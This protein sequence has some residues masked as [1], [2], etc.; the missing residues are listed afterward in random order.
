LQRAQAQVGLATIAGVAGDGPVTVAY[1]TAAGHQPVQRAGHT[2]HVALEAA[3]KVGN[4]R[5]VVI[6]HGSGGS[7]WGL[8]DLAEALV[9]A[10]YVVAFPEHAGD[11]A[12]DSGRVGP[13]SW[14]RRPAEVSRAIDAVGADARF[15]TLLKL[16]M[17]GMYGMS[18]GGHTAL[19]LAGGSWS[20]AGLLRHCEQHIRSDFTA[21]AGPQVRL[22]GGWLDEAKILGTLAVLRWKLTDETV[23]QHTDPRIAAVAAAVPFAADFDMATL[24]KPKVPLALLSGP[25][26]AWL[27]PLHHSGQVL[28]ACSRCEHLAN[29]PLA[30]HGAYLSP[31]PPA[32]PTAIKPLL[33]DAPGFDRPAAVAI[34]QTALRGF[35]NKHLLP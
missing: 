1:P 27:N 8:W 29:P 5:L 20:A 25:R 26:D 34:I 17:V 11:N 28:H 22:D 13:L 19:S 21:C 33:A 30:G 2:L 24:S 7:P 32:L 18:A 23:H 3:P 31:L 4:R 6:S 15:A 10:G 16:D 14:A 35:F 12:Q 9:R